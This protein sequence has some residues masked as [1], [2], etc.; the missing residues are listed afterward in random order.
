MRDAFEFMEEND[1]TAPTIRTN[2]GILLLIAGI[3]L[4][5]LLVV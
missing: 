3:I 5:I 2:R 1:V 4:M